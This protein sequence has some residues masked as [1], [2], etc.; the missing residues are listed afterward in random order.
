MKEKLGAKTS[1]FLQLELK[2]TLRVWWTSLSR[3]L[4]SMMKPMNRV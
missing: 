3:L 2:K 4:I 1:S